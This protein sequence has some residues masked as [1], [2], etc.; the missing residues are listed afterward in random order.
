M[1]LDKPWTTWDLQLDG[2]MR[3]S[4]STGRDYQR[5][6]RRWHIEA[7]AKRIMRDMRDL[8]RHGFKVTFP[9]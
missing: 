8:Q 3:A 9:S 7:D 2:H 4:C 6:N 5:Q 1:G